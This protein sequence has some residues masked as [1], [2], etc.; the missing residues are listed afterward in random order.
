M[1]KIILTVISLI[2]MVVATYGQQFL[3]STKESNDLK[4]VPYSEAT[5]EVLELYDLYNNYYDG[6]GFNKENFSEFFGMDKKENNWI[7]DI[8]ESMILAIR[9]H[10][11]NGSAIM[12]MC[13]DE[14]NVNM[15]VFSNVN[16]SGYNNTYNGEIEKHRV[17]FEKW[18]KTLLN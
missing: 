6:A 2:G 8:E 4:Y 17:R 12:V 18:F 3:W 11:D 5:K 10:I 13:I 7:Y 16:M 15:V 1:K 9:L 14:N